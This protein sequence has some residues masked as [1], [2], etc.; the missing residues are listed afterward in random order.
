[1]NA[2]AVVIACGKEEEL[3]TGT[4]V[5]FLPLGNMPILAH[6]LKTLEQASCVDGIIIAVSKSRVDA[7]MH[8]IRRYGFTKIKGIVIGAS[9]RHSTMKIVLSKL[10]VQ[11]SVLLIH[12]ASRPFVSRSVVEDTVKAAKRYGCAIAA[13]KLTDAI[14][15]APKGMKVADCIDRNAA[16]AAETPQAFKLDVM[17]KVLKSKNIKVIDDESEFVR[18]PAEVH[19]VESGSLN[20]KIRTSQELSIAA[21]Y[22]NAKIV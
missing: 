8:L 12:E 9:T 7:A 14:K 18:K 10:P 19:M 11:P 16:W 5:G 3:E 20:I 15:V 21:A 22:I 4:E 1:M 2:L 6:S 13:H 17:K